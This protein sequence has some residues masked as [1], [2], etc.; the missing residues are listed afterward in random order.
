MARKKREEYGNDS[1]SALKG[2]DRVRKR[3]GVIFGSDGLQGCEHAVFEI[4]SNSID[5]A[6]E[7]YGDRI[8]IT[9]Y[10]D[11]SIQ[12]EDFGRGIPVDY[13]NNEQKYN[14]ELV[15]CELYAGGKYK[16]TSS[17]SYEF[18][19]GLNGLGLCATQYASRY[20]DVEILRDGSRY[21]L[22]FERG[23][24]VGGLHKEPTKLK[25]T[26]T[27][28]RWLPDIDVFTDIQV[29]LAYFQDVLKRQAVVNAGL[30]F[31]LHFETDEGMHDEEFY[32]E[33]GITDYVG[34][35]AGE[36][37]LTP[38]QYW[39]D[40]RYG[41]DREDKPEYKVKLHVAMCFSNRFKQCE[42]YHNSS[43]LEHGGSPERAV[44]V[45]FVSM[46][47][48]FLKQNGKYLKNESKITF[49]DVEDCL[50]LV[51]SSF[52]TV[53]SYEN[54]T[55][56]SITNKF[57]Y[58]AMT[59]FLKH[60]LEIYFIENP[61]DA[62]RIAEQVLINKRSRENAEKTRLNLKKK[63]A[64]SLDISNRVQ[65]FVDC[66]TKDV[67]LR[68]IYIVEGD[69][70][71]G[72]CKLGRDSQFQAI[73]PVRGKILN[74]LK[75]EYDKIF[76]NDI[77]SDIIKV[78]G[79]GVEV[80]SKAN[81]DLASFDLS[82][83]RWNKIV[84]C[85]DAD[86]DGFQI[87]TLI[88]TM[89]YRL[90]PTLIEEGYVYIAESPLYEI[91]TKNKTFFAYSDAEKANILAKIGS[92]KYGIQ[93]SKGLGEN[94]PDMMWLTTMNPET[95]RLIKVTPQDA[96]NTSRMFDL[97]LGDNLSGR[98]EFIAEFGHL[99]LDETDVM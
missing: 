99:Y 46:I 78:L 21:T 5:E 33:N 72:A 35:L 69:S 47:D 77:I 43:Y 45:A 28:I 67:S 83:L 18:S 20:M 70:A 41:R 85:T 36:E 59:A 27:K 9:R 57:I 84:I 23:E 62:Q 11:G 10:R 3:P 82:G 68:E 61:D 54:Q 19:L 66:R 81:K 13:N 40:K 60:N 87:R 7:G 49:A 12:I 88:L 1:I 58:E 90:T 4:L 14:W 32:Y 44:K 48:Q 64:G 63:L 74:C 55:K 75:A 25:T 89:L 29:S 86:V 34:E 71:L 42:Y 96:E 31:E 76:K 53:T 16:N 22:R 15:F 2:A 6:R 38:I 8:V 26:G 24:N 51:S 91:T 97:L 94:E 80:K 56:K 50:I 92:Q 17:E 93:R 98:K 37:A 52:S 30:R 65:K 73:I 39:Q 79:C 95:R